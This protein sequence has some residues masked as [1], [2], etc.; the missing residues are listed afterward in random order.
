MTA[1]GFYKNPKKPEQKRRELVRAFLEDFM[2]LERKHTDEVGWIALKFSTT[3]DKATQFIEDARL[4]EV[5]E[6]NSRRGIRESPTR[7]PVT[8]RDR[9]LAEARGLK[10]EH[11]ENPE[12]DRALAELIY[13]TVGGDSIAAVRAEIGLGPEPTA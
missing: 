9:L 4:A 8:T 7:T 1:R 12:Y 11:G 13:W 2:R 10:S 3:R 6:P 5:R